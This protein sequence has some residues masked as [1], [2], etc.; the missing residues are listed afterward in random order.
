MCVWEPK[1]GMIWSNFFHLW[2]AMV[3]DVR[4][5]VGFSIWEFE[6]YETVLEI[7]KVIPKNPP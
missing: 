4:D 1:I 7:P 3:I 5:V 2:G 6:S